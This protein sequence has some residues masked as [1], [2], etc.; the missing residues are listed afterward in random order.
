MLICMIGFAGALGAL[1]RYGLAQATQTLVGR[2][3]P[4]GVFVVNL[5]GCL[6][7]GVVY[8]ATEERGLLA[9]QWRTILLAGFMG[10]FTTFSSF[11]HDTAA[12]ARFGQT[13]LALVNLVGQNALG[14]LALLLGM[15]LGRLL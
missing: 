7:F 5:V 15:R 9:G 1:A 3:F 10:A 6:A 2:S 14:F 13:G 12:L 4:L 8:A 11:I